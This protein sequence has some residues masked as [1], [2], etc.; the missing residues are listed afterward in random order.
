L[1][2]LAFLAHNTSSWRRFDNP[3]DNQA[4]SGENTSRL[5]PWLTLI[6]ID[7]R[8]DTSAHVVSSVVCSGSAHATSQSH[9]TQWHPSCTFS[10]I[11]QF[12]G[13]TGVNWFLQL[14]CD[15]LI[16][17]ERDVAIEQRFANTRHTEPLTAQF[18]KHWLN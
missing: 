9:V 8:V 14:T 17:E 4:F 3:N 12:L 10:L 13:V 6:L 2:A 5:L 18:E 16:I 15:R 1:T 7:T 11:H